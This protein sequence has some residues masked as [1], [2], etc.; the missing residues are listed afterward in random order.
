MRTT[1]SVPDPLFEEARS[2][3]ADQPF[4][5]F[6]REAIELRVEQLRRERLARLLAEGYRAE[7][8]DLS[9]DAEWEAVEV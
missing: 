5:A 2:L 3:A 8:K 6:A 1:I 4:S 9:L 7:A